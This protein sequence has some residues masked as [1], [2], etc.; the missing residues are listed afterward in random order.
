[1]VPKGDSEPR[2]TQ[3]LGRKEGKKLEIDRLSLLSSFT[4][5]FSPLPQMLTS[6]LGMM[7]TTRQAVAM[8]KDRV[9]ITQAELERREVG[10]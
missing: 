7:E 4:L 8:L 5:L 3:S 9:M 1:M 2:Q 6:V 10:N